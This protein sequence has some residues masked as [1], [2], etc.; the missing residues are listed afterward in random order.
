MH[1]RFSRWSALPTAALVVAALASGCD[2]SDLVNYVPDASVTPSSLDFQGVQIGTT[3]SQVVVITNTGS[4]PLTLAPAKG[5]PF[6]D[7]FTFDIEGDSIGPAGIARLTVNFTPTQ[8]QSYASVIEVRTN[9]PTEDGS[10]AVITIDIAGTGLASTLDVSPRRVDFGNVV[11][12]TT[13]TLTITLTNDSDLD[14]SLDFD[15]DN[16]GN[17]RECN[18]TAGPESFCVDLES[19]ARYRDGVLALPSGQ[20]TTLSVSFTPTTVGDATGAFT[21]STC[22]ESSCTQTINLLGKGV[23]SGLQCSPT[24]LAFG[25]VNPGQQSNLSV[26]CENIANESITILGWSIASASD[27][28]FTVETATPQLLNLGDTVSI[29]A[30]FAPTALGDVTGAL[31][32][33][34]NNSDPLQATVTVPLTGSGGGPNITVLPAELRFGDVALI[35]PSRKPLSITNTGYSALTVSAIDADADASG[36]FFLTSTDGS[37]PSTTFTIQPGASQQI[38]IRF[39]PTVEGD[40]TSS[41]R[42][43]SDDSDEPTLLVPVYGTGR[44]VPPCTFQIV[45]SRLD[46][47]AVTQTRSFIRNF[48]VQ[49]QGSDICI[50]TGVQMLDDASGAFSLVDGDI[51]SR[52]IAAGA[53]EIIPVQFQPNASGSFTG[54]VELSISSRTQT[55]NTIPLTGVASEGE[56]L[57]VPPEVDYGVIGLGCRSRDRQIQLYNT[58]SDPIVIDSIAFAT[59][60]NSAFSLSNLPTG[61]PGTA[62]TLA[63]GA[64]TTFDVGFRADAISAYAGAVEIQATINSVSQT[65]YV[66]LSGRGALDAVQVD[67]FAQLGKPKVDIIFYIDASSSMSQ[68]QAA[69]ASNLGAFVQFAEAQGLDYQIGVTSTAIDS[70][71][72]A[73]RL[74]S[75]AVG[76]TQASIYSG[77]AANRIVTPQSVPSPGAVFAANVSFPY[78]SGVAND[79]SGLAAAEL[80]LSPPVIY[81]HNSGMVRSDAVLSLIFVS[82]EPDQSSGSVDY[83]INFFLSIKGFRNTNLFSASAITAPYPPGSCSGSGGSAT[84]S[85][86]YIAVAERTGGVFQS[87][88]TSSWS[89]SLED[90][91][92]TAFGFKSRFFLTNQPVISSLAVLVDG[93]S[94]PQQSA[95]GTINWT[96]D[97]STNSINFAPYSTPEPGSQIRVEYS[98]ECL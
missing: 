88:C 80:S 28:A 76:T 19:N 70:D 13:E 43:T 26:T 51:T 8:E 14:A 15:T 86:R 96:Y 27:A 77:P 94:L 2:D 33:E 3:R 39:A 53:S 65:Y 84:S 82:D 7:V 6:V 90:L 57:I 67:E 50:I 44:N 78:D 59:P 36:S 12:N 37:T 40:I 17:V 42:I 20:S 1:S 49:N 45:P 58:G 35:A 32:I 64:S 66:A 92:T 10:Y 68:E 81:G 30:T 74:A 91:S 21:V 95:S 98:V 72:E 69:I 73:G 97:Y 63:S 89:R 85:G 52:E 61:L 87:I 93:A 9:I 11:V 71:D 25:Q 46:F 75:A 29:E 83:Y 56:L 18:A 23:T 31:E 60:V 41:V 54:S 48:E 34:T 5:N 24:S 55:Y 38:W 16:D 79:E 4:G 62:Y 22:E 47:G